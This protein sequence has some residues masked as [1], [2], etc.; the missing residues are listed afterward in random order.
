MIQRSC[1]CGAVRWTQGEVPPSATA[2]SCTACRR[3]VTPW[4]F[5]PAAG[6]DLSRGAVLEAGPLFP[7][8]APAGV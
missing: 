8:F 2:G 1:L 4:A 6:D 3:C 5:L 7:E